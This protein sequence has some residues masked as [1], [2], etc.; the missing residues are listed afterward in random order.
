M[1][2]IYRR[3]SGCVFIYLKSKKVSDV[4]LRELIALFHRYK[5]DTQL[6]AIFLSGKNKIWLKNDKA[7]WY[8]NMFKA[9]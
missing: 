4:C 1:C 8:K 5:I 3:Q 6:L 9:S 2:K 7:F